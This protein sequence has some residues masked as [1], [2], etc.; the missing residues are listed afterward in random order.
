MKQKPLI[1]P[2]EARPDFSFEDEAGGIVCGIDEVGRGPLA[3]PVVAAAVVLRRDVLPLE[4]LADINDSKQV[5]PEK[6]EFLFKQLQ[7]YAYVSLA[8]CSVADID[9]IN[10]LQASLLAMRRAHL[11]LH[12]LMGEAPPVLALVDGNMPP[13]LAH[14]TRVK[15]I[16]QGDARSFSIAAASIIAKHYR[17]AIMKKHARRFPQYGWHTN[18]GYSTAEHLEALEIHGITPLHRRSFAPVS[19]QIV[20]QSSANS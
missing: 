20:K 11:K 9:R 18:V 7:N 2:A 10:I 12:K 8:E 14:K 3:G 4:L 15:T 17:D 13:R 1:E 19:K 6:R 16:V 5:P